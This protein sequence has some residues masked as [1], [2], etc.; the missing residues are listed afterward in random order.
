MLILYLM[1]VTEIIK[2]KNLLIF[3]R[4][5]NYLIY[6]DYQITS[7]TFKKDKVII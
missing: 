5:S 7:I 1:C 3:N 6:E 2:I 4:V